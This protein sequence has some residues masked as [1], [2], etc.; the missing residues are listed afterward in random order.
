MFKNKRVAFVTSG[1]MDSNF[2]SGGIKLNYILLNG[3]KKQNYSIDL[4][5][6]RI[7]T[8]EYKILD[9]RILSQ[10]NFFLFFLLSYTSFFFLLTLLSLYYII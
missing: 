8:Y 9:K 4:Y 5:C 10:L 3:L 6:D 7:V 1:Y 2:S